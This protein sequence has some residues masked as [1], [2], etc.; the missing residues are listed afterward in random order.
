MVLIKNLPDRLPIFRLSTPRTGIQKLC[1]IAGAL[2]GTEEFK[3]RENGTRIVLESGE[4]VVETNLKS[5]G[6]WA[7]D[8][9]Q[10]WQVESRPELPDDESARKIAVNLCRE[11]DLLPNLRGNKTINMEF[12]GIGR[13]MVAVREDRR[14]RQDHQIDTQV[15]FSARIDVGGNQVPV[16]GGGSEFKLT[17]GDRGNVIGFSGVWRD[18]E[19]ADIDAAIISP[20]ESLKQ[21]EMMTKDVQVVDVETELAYYSAPMRQQQDFM[22]PVYVYRA[23]IK[24]NAE[25]IPMRIVT[26]PATNFRGAEKLR[27]IQPERQRILE[28]IVPPKKAVVLDTTDLLKAMPKIHPATFLWPLQREAGT[29]WIGLS[30][31][32]SGSQNNA[33]GFIDGLNNAGWKINFNWGDANAWESDWHR[34]DDTWVDACDF[35][36]YTGHANMNGWTLASPDDGSLNFTETGSNPET[37]GDMWGQQDLE[38]MVIAACGPLQDDLIGNG[39]GDV[40]D[41]W[42]GA[43]D[44]MHLMMG[45]GGITYDNEEEGETIIEYA[46][47]GDSLI[48]AWFRTAR[49]IQP[50]SNGAAAPN[51]PNIYVGAMYCY[52][53]GDASPGNDHLWGHGSV[54]PDPANSNVRVCMWTTT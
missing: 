2:F 5:G 24:V 48:N 6:I 44:G 12:S 16:V 42:G 49:E 43:F 3:I 13:T 34:K 17:L 41:R 45:Y 11:H 18:V 19:D 40:L 29:S 53:A 46:R 1:N 28:A 50:S 20:D 7:A 30:G 8:T 4:K 54:A 23:T 31:G 14:H 9:K 33:K 38:W 27:E 32:L 51:G 52:R 25:I 26:L 35:V 36:F 21:F 10:L 47:D 15:N 22:Y 37:P 39:G